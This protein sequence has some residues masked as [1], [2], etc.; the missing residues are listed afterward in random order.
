MNF[1]AHYYFDHK[2]N[3]PYFNL[4]L[5]LPDL[6]RNSSTVI[7]HLPYGFKT[8]NQNVQWLADGFQKHLT[9]DKIFHHCAD[10]VSFNKQITQMLR[11]SGSR[12]HRDWFLAHIL[13][14]LLIDRTILMAHP[15]IAHE[16]YA[17]L[18]K[19]HPLALSEFLSEAGMI[20]QSSFQT[21]F[22]KFKKVRYLNNYDQ[23]E[24]V[25]FALTKIAEKVH[26]NISEP[27]HKK[28]ILSL[29]HE[30]HH[31]FVPFVKRLEMLL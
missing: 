24:S 29:I 7:H 16:L 3:N 8:E 26:I 9:T 15:L 6:I 28:V 19:I 10:F 12:F 20:D 14:E 11:N 30:L 18:D 27:G 25:A 22:E 4:G 17:D 1:L 31:T 5:L 13:T 23:A 21:G 2:G